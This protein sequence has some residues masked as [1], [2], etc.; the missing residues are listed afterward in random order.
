MKIGICCSAL[1]HAEICINAGADFIE[2]NNNKISAMSDEEFNAVLE[3]SQK[4]PGKFLACNGLIPGTHRV[5][6]E[7]VD[8]DAIRDF[9]EFSFERLA[10]L[11]VK[12]LVFG[13]SAAKKVPEG[14]SFETAMEQL[15]KS[16]QIFADVAKKHSQIVV[17][18]PLRHVECNIINLV[19]E[20][21]Q[22]ADLSERDN[23]MA[24]V[25]FFHM[26]QNEETLTELQKY[27]DSLGHVH[28]ASPVARKL[29]T[30]D[31]GANYK[32]FMD[33]IRD[34]NPDQ[35]VSY[36]GKSE[37]DPKK[38]KTMFSFLKSL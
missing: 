28:I 11:G 2:V 38:L 7:N 19:S 1:D 9:C 26:M 6:G 32:A 18:E 29:P 24:H 30:F 17:I 10:R 27:A 23:V 31:D 5:T 16:V 4:Y 36:E 35:T 13:S 33:I 20:S 25:D 21:K 34:A 15:V 3:L 22:L 12:I 37:F 8:F 14:F